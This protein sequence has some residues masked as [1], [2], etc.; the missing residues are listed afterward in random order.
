VN[1]EGAAKTQA[2]NPY[3]EWLHLKQ[4]GFTPQT[5]GS[6]NSLNAGNATANLQRLAFDTEHHRYLPVHSVGN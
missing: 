3:L 4:G 2:F 1:Q 5:G 6:S